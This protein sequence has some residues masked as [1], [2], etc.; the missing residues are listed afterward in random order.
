MQGRLNRHTQTLRSY[1]KISTH[2]VDVTADYP[3][4]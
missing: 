3:P 4:P 1:E 2:P